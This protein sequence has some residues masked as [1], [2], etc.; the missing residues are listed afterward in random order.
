MQGADLSLVPDPLPFPW[1][2]SAED[3]KAPGFYTA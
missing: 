2:L 3:T 1:S